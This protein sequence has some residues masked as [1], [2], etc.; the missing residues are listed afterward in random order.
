MPQAWPWYALKNQVISLKI[1]ML[2]S[3]DT[4]AEGGWKAKD[5]LNPPDQVPLGQRK[6]QDKVPACQESTELQN[7]Q[8]VVS[9]NQVPPSK[10]H[11]NRGSP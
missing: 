2:Q 11:Y 5:E 10:S 6:L 7:D 8:C 9:W 3:P 1:P 4:V